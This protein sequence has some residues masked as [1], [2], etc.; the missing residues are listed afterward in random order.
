MGMCVYVIKFGMF[1]FRMKSEPYELLVRD[2]IKSAK[3][4]N[5]SKDPCAE[6]FIPQNEVRHN[7]DPDGVPM[8]STNFWICLY[9]TTFF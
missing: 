2:L 3:T 5:H 9:K 7:V 6:D 4:L 8:S 1:Y